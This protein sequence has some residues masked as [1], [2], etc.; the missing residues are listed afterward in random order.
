MTDGN[1][2][3][4]AVGCTEDGDFGF[5][6]GSSTAIKYACSQIKPHRALYYHRHPFRGYLAGAAPVTVST[7][8]W[9]TEKIMGLGVEKAFELAEKAELPNEYLY[10]PQGDR[11]PFGDPQLGASFLRIWPEVSSRDAAR[12]MIFRAMILGL[13]FLENYYK[14]L[15][16]GMFHREIVEARIM[17]GGTRSPWWNKLRA[18]IYEIPVRVMDERPGLG[19]LMP[20]VLKL[21]LFKNLREAQDALLRARGVYEPDK[22]LGLKY[23][24]ARDNFLNRWNMVREASAVM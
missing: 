16:E 3:A 10:F 4:I 24:N 14:T 11:E 13:T 5:S 9:F 21:N 19:A 6:S 18:S 1:A 23:R 15:L 2:A 22:A 7:A 17:G 20:A 12:G 8:R